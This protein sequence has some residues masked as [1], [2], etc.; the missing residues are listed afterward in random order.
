A[1]RYRSR[2]IGAA[3]LLLASLPRNPAGLSCPREE[4]TLR[5][6]EPHA[7]GCHRRQRGT[8]QPA[9]PDQG[10][11]SRGRGHWRW[12]GDRP[13]IRND[14]RLHLLSAVEDRRPLQA[15]VWTGDVALL[16]SQTA[17]DRVPDQSRNIRSAETPDLEN[18]GRG[19]YI[20]LREVVADHVD[21]GED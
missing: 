8:A 20:Y 4:R 7:E 12:R 3:A 15:S 9:A 18:A 19:G 16:T 6:Y 21:A 11:C 2:S 1:A 5:R 14:R 13:S 10:L 17:L